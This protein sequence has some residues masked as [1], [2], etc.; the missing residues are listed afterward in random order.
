M[1]ERISTCKRKRRYDSYNSAERALERI[2]AI[3]DREDDE[4]KPYFCKFCRG[5]HLG[6]KY[7]PRENRE[8]KQE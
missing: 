4:L 6:H 5:I 3:F 7:G 2:E 8:T 1:K